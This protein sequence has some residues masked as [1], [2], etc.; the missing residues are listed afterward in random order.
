MKFTKLLFILI[1]FFKTET[2]FSDDNLFHVNNIKIEKKGIV[3][4][5]ALADAGIKKAFNELISRI[6]LEEDRDK[7]L[8][9]SITSVKE[10]VKF[11]QVVNISDDSNNNELI[12]FNVKFDKS[13]IHDIFFKRGILYSEIPDKEFYILP[14]L[15]EG[16][17]V[18]I[19]N[20]NYFYENW[21]KV[22]EDNLIDFILPLENIEIIK[23]INENKN[24]LIDLDV[25]SLFKEYQKKNLALII[26]EGKKTDNKKVYIKTIIQEK[27][28]SKSLNLKA[29][30]YNNIKIYENVIIEIKKELKNLI[31]S[32]NLIDIRTPS[33]LN[34]K[35]DLNKKSNL[36]ELNS[37]IKNIESI[38][39]IYIQEFNKEYMNIRIKYLG[40]LEKLINQLKNKN[41]D[42]KFINDKWVIKTL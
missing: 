29:E 28:I 22:S 41:I 15:I 12:N 1:V 33:F 35:L 27:N 37:R 11:Y 19:F 3:T 17:E 39:H 42:L 13:K 7:I 24:N 21:N 38:E 5:D 9:L 16:N 23:K 26:I 32:K 14:I 10:L 34:T 30:N 4:N 6:L 18:F 2:L 8:D 25:N 20:N 31:K 40:K 36:I